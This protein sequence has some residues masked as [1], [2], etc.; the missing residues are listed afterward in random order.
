M[1]VQDGKFHK[2]PTAKRV[3]H[4]TQFYADSMRNDRS[5]PV[6]ATDSARLK[7]PF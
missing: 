4:D 2:L 3:L 7:P 6:G 5:T 1:A